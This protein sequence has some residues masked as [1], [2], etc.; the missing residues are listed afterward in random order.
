MLDKDLLNWMGATQDEVVEETQVDVAL[1]V[2][3]MTGKEVI[4]KAESK[5][6]EQPSRIVPKPEVVIKQGTIY[7]AKTATVQK[8][9]MNQLDIIWSPTRQ[10]FESAIIA[11][12]IKA[13]AIGVGHG[14]FLL[15]YRPWLND[16]CLVRVVFN[17]SNDRDNYQ[18]IIVR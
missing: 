6:G 2:S 10:F 15:A 1:R 4:E 7:N 18:L 9:V 5:A 11:G 14:W 3:R 17:R 13:E 8:K 12:R 16:F